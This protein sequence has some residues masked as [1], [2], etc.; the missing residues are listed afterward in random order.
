[1]LLD[2]LK[3]GLATTKRERMVGGG[4]QTDVARVRI[5]EAGRCNM[6]A[7]YNQAAALATARPLSR[8]AE[9][10]RR[11]ILLIIRRVAIAL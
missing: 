5:T 6:P 1:M 3:A 7:E 8:Y 4:R 10:K 11:L 2:L 9:E